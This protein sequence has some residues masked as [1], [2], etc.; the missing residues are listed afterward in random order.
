[1]TGQKERKANGVTYFSCRALR[2]YDHKSASS[3][4][5]LFNHERSG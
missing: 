5:K 2:S 4:E 1:L 3:L